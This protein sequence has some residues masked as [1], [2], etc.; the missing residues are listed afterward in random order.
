M[1]GNPLIPTGLLNRVI[2]A[3][4]W[5]NFPALNISASYLG[6]EGIRFGFDGNAVQNH[7]V[8]AG[9]VPSP[10]PYQMVSVRVALLKTNG[11]GDAYKV[12][13]AQFAVLGHGK[14]FPDTTALSPFRL[15]RASIM[16]VAEIPMDGSDPSMV[17]TLQGFIVQNNGIWT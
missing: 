8:M 7:E 14:V 11:L 15:Y 2:A 10:E 17:V 6:K 3:V 1:A 5:D 12:Q 9:I 4:Q 16:T 13:M